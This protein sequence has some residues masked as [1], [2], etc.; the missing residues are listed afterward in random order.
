MRGGR[1]WTVNTTHSLVP[2]GFQSSQLDLTMGYEVSNKTS[3]FYIYFVTGKDNK[4]SF[5]IP[6]NTGA[7]LNSKHAKTAA[8]QSGKY[9]TISL[10]ALRELY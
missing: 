7:N 1:L 3:F 10:G 2:A 9:K 5:S 8:K 6:G 4:A